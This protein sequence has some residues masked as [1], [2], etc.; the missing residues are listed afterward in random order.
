MG[1]TVHTGYILSVG[2]FPRHLGRIRYRVLADW[3]GRTG[4]ETGSDEN[5]KGKP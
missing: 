5:I 1:G 2:S 3:L 4:Y